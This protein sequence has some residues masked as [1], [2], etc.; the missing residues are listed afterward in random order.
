MISRSSRPATI[1]R[2]TA[3]AVGLGVKTFSESASNRTPPNFSSRN[4]TNFVS[5]IL[6]RRKKSQFIFKAGL[7][8]ANAGEGNGDDCQRTRLFVDSTR[9]YQ[10]DG[11]II[12]IC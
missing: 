12:L 2:T 6:V 8:N 11:P 4:L 5:R 3:V 9:Q 1:S 10:R 7:S